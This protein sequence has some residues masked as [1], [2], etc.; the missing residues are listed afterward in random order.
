MKQTPSQ[1]SVSILRAR[2]IETLTDGVFAIVMTLLVLNLS[3]SNLLNYSIE[4][5]I[6]TII[7]Q[8]SQFIFTFFVLAIYWIFHHRLFHY[9]IRSDIYLIWLNMMFLM[10]IA[11]VPFSNSLLN[12]IDYFGQIAIVFYTTDLLLSLITLCIMWWHATRH[13]H[14]IKPATTPEEIIRLRQ[15]LEGAI[16]IFLMVIAISFVSLI[17]S[18]LLLTFLLIYTVISQII[19]MKGRSRLLFSLTCIMFNIVTAVFIITV[20]IPLYLDSWAT[21][22]ATMIG[23]IGIGLIVGV[24]YNFFMSATYWGPSSWIWMFSSILVVLITWFFYKRNWITLRK[25]LRLI[26]V[27]IITG[28]LNTIL[29]VVIIH[30]ANLPQYQGTYPVFT[31][32]YNVTN[33]AFLSST[34]ENFCVEIVD[35]TIAIFLAAIAI[36]L[37]NRFRKYDEYTKYYPKISFN[38]LTKKRKK[39][40]FIESIKGKK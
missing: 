26:S 8:L 5:S 34:I 14:L 39:N 22:L 35:K 37:I 25:P 27:G 4:Q 2:R 30:V 6:Q 33:N 7:S 10:T 16:V 1:S 38:F 36:S 28:I 13:S 40:D 24:V 32:F 31:F 3:V 23:G 12:N 20:K 15:S 19:P 17:W 11:L 9:I 21:S 18:Q 29:A